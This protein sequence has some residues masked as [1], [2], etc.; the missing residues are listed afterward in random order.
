M[1]ISSRKIRS[2]DLSPPLIYVFQL[3]FDASQFVQS[4]SNVLFVT[5]IELNELNSC[6]SIQ[7]QT[8]TK[9]AG[10][11]IEHGIVSRIV[12]VFL[13]ISKFIINLLSH[14]RQRHCTPIP[15]QLLRTILLSSQL[16]IQ[17]SCTRGYQQP[18]HNRYLFFAGKK[19][20]NYCY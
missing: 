18:P 10:N 8:T 9:K 3:L 5:R 17:V 14:L 13:S 1:A 15:L 20:E 16:P 4:F 7:I 11:F 6:H 2:I 19:W 12:N